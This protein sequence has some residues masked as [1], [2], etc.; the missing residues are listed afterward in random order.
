MAFF[1]TLL[2]TK[3]QGKNHYTLLSHD[4]LLLTGDTKLPNISLR[5]YLILIRLIIHFLERVNTWNWG[6]YVSIY[7]KVP[8]PPSPVAPKLSCCSF[9]LTLMNNTWETLHSSLFRDIENANR[10]ILSAKGILILLSL[11]RKKK[12]TFHCNTDVNFSI[13]QMGIDDS[14]FYYFRITRKYAVSI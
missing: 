1:F 7:L 5:N 12:N 13:E 9:N 3:L 6:A 2:Y 11:V 10:Y 8:P 14:L 4:Y